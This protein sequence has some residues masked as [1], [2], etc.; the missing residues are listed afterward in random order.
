MRA[1]QAD[2]PELLQGAGDADPGVVVGDEV[3]GG[4][5]GPGLFDRGVADGAAAAVD[6]DADD[7]GEQVAVDA[8]GVARIVPLVAEAE[9]EEA[10]VGVEE[11]GTAVVPEVVVALIDQDQFR[12]RVGISAPS[13][14]VKRERRL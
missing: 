6:V 1:A 8:L 5:P 3:V 10:I 11:Q 14:T 2:A 7:A 4:G 13:G 9:V 12:V